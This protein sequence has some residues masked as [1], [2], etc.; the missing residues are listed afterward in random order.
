MR[1]EGATGSILLLAPTA[2]ATG[3]A[4]LP[5]GCPV[6]QSLFAAL[7]GLGELRAAVEAA[8]PQ[9]RLRDRLLG[10]VAKSTEFATAG[11]GQTGGLRKKSLKRARTALLRF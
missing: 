7:C 11:D 5:P 9:G 2:F 8:A 6:G 1:S 4:T 3:R 10:S